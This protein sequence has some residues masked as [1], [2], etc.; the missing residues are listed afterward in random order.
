MIEHR[1]SLAYVIEQFVIFPI[2]VKSLGSARGLDYAQFVGG[3]SIIVMCF[4]LSLLISLSLS[5]YLFIYL[6]LSLS[7][8]MRLIM[9]HCI[10]SVSDSEQTLFYLRL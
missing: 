5:I 6:S 10:D 1:K 2:I 4:S 3:T 7:L 9:N 8:S